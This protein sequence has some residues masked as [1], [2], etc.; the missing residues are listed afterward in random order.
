MSIP[1]SPRQG[2]MLAPN[3][4]SFQSQ[5]HLADGFW[6]LMVRFCLSKITPKGLLLTILEAGLTWN[7]MEFEVNCSDLT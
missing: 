7:E 3:F 2:D 5:T 1:R 4:E 6:Q